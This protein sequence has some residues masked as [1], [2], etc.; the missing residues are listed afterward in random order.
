MRGNVSQAG[1]KSQSSC[2]F[3]YLL[4]SFCFQSITVDTDTRIKMVTRTKQTR[5]APP[6]NEFTLPFSRATSTKSKS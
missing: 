1:A 5:A 2:R 6:P 3:F 4:C